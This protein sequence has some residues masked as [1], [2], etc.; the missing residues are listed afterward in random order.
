MVKA[1]KARG[2]TASGY[3]ASREE[4]RFGLIQPNDMTTIKVLESG[5]QERRNAGTQ[6]RRNAGT[7]ERPPCACMGPSPSMDFRRQEDEH[8]PPLCVPMGLSKAI[9]VLAWVRVFPSR[10]RGS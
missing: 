9:R 4:W 5:T 1:S 6:E 3:W 7:Q 2:V 10:Q 8:S